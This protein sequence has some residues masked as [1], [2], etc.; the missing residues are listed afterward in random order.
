M[1]IVWKVSV[2]V[3]FSLCCSISKRDSNTNL[4]AD[5]MLRNS[6]NSFVMGDIG[7]H[8]IGMNIVYQIYNI[9]SI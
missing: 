3:E 4:N 7:V 6:R 8:V 5:T 1:I 2:V 9:G